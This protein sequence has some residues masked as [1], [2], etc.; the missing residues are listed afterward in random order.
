MARRSKPKRGSLKKAMNAVRGATNTPKANYPDATKNYGRPKLSSIDLIIGGFAGLNPAEAEQFLHWIGGFPSKAL[1]VYPIRPVSNPYDLNL[2]S[3]TVAM[4]LLDRLNWLS[5]FLSRSQCDLE[6]FVA[7]KTDFETLFLTGEYGAAQERLDEIEDKFG[8]SVWLI[9][10]KIAL[11]QLSKGLDAQKE[12]ARSLSKGTKGRLAGVT[13]YWI[14]QRNEESTILSRFKNRLERRIPNW[15]VGRPVR[16]AYALILGMSSYDQLSDERASFALGTVATSSL[17]DAYSHTILALE[18]LLM[19]DSWAKSVEKLR[20]IAERLPRNEPRVLNIL[21]LLNNV[22][23]GMAQA[24][25][26]AIDG[27]LEARPNIAQISGPTIDAALFADFVH[28]S[29]EGANGRIPPWLLGSP[30]AGLY[31]LVEASIA[32]PPGFEGTI[33]RGLKLLANLRYFSVSDSVQGLLLTQ[34]PDY[35]PAHAASAITF[36]L[37]SQ[38]LHPWHML[39]LPSNRIESLVK[40]KFGNS[41]LAAALKL[42]LQ[43]KLAHNGHKCVSIC[44]IASRIRLSSGDPDGAISYLELNRAPISAR[45]LGA[46]LVT[47]YLKAGKLE[48][49]ISKAAEICANDSELATLLPLKELVD[50]AKRQRGQ[51]KDNLSIA[52]V[53]HFYHVR[54]TD[55]DV[56]QLLQFA[57]E[58]FILSCGVTRPSDL[59]NLFDQLDK[60]KLIY[61]LKLICV[62]DVMDVS[63]WLFKKSRETLEERISVCTL[64]IEIDSRIEASYRDEIKEITKQLSIQDGLED[65]DRSRVYVNIPKLQTWAESE[66]RESYERYQAYLHAGVNKHDIT[67]FPIILKDYASG[68][69]SLERFAEY[70][71][72]EAG[73]LLLDIYSSIVQKYLHDPEIGLDAYLSMRIR[74][75]SLAGHIR[76]PLEEEGLLA[77]RDKGTNQYRLLH[78]PALDDPTIQSSQREA[79]SRCVVSFSKEFN[80]LIDG[81]IRDQLQ[82]RGEA[83]PRGLFVIAPMPLV[84]YYLRATIEKGNTLPQLVTNA[85]D[86]IGIYLN[87][88]LQSVRRHITE[89]FSEQISRCVDHFRRSLDDHVHQPLRSELQDL[90]THALP[91]LHASIERAAS[92][93]APDAE[94]ER[95]ALR[96]FEQIVDIAIQATNNAHRGFSP[97]FTIDIEDLGLQSNETFIEFTDILFTILDNIYTHSGLDREPIIA[98]NISLVS[99]RSDG[100]CE[101]KVSVINKVTSDAI[102]PANERRLDKIREQIDSGDYKALSKVE[103][104][105]GLLKLKRVVAS[106]PRQTLEFGYLPDRSE[107]FV[108]IVM[109]MILLPDLEGTPQAAEAC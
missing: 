70:P 62:P 63:F 37:G 101:V 81:L 88:S 17:V 31:D 35:S 75:G 69:G 1:H 42:A 84:I 77:V 39:V 41:A 89:E 109:A 71:D 97:K 100:A 26:E 73:Q 22:F 78:T 56:F 95:R 87:L 23:T 45:R 13:S 83:K 53:L 10:V 19:R 54:H 92:W 51:I 30:A 47:A 38:T 67:D 18:A 86:M 91:D 108:E 64:L 16:D 96:T 43:G 32:R 40:E 76:G 27:L 4:P 5:L 28:L 80:E 44:E 61:F 103:G 11:L 102:T 33:E 36:F 21:S 74:H 15:K 93:F 58:D 29:W 57:Y 3:V 66:L 68:K 85:L 6:I 106:D 55:D 104:G 94:S 60:T 25:T 34:H 9:D 105:T 99:Q 49:A 8:L 59:K 90:V 7:L 48:E 72:D 98:I 82:I 65:V 46:L 12:F 107:F 52:I 20:S 2:G 24:N 50:E 14:S 79:A